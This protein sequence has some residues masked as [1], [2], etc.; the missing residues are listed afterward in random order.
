MARKYFLISEVRDMLNQLDVQYDPKSTKPIIEQLLLQT[1][2]AQGYNGTKSS[3]TKISEFVRNTVATKNQQ[4]YEQNSIKN[5]ADGNDTTSN[6]VAAEGNDETNE[7]DDEQELV[8]LQQL[9][10]KAKQEL[11]LATEKLDE[12]NKQIEL[13]QQVTRLQQWNNQLAIDSHQL[14]EI[15]AINLVKKSMRNRQQINEAKRQLQELKDKQVQ[16]INEI[17]QQRI[18]D[19]NIINKDYVTNIRAQLVHNLDLIKPT[20]AARKIQ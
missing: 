2:K 14:N 1:I 11:K 10:I 5:S 4:N 20:Q 7:Y 15:M 17:Q 16:K 18:N 13:R 19:M 9:R 12:I 8:Q 6:E 3:I